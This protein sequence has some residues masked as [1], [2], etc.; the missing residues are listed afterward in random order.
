MKQG[1]CR[2]QLVQSVDLADEVICWNHQLS[3]SLDTLIPHTRPPSRCFDNI[4]SIIQ[5]CL[6]TLSSQEDLII[7]SNSRFDGLHCRL[8]HA[9][10]ATM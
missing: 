6:S 7:M 5:Y 3:W 8:I 4:D 10:R 1:I 2:H 9:L